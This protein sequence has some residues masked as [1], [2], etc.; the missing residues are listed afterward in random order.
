MVWR[1]GC[2]S[3]PWMSE[4]RRGSLRGALT[5]GRVRIR[6]PGPNAVHIFKVP[7]A[8]GASRVRRPRG[9]GT[10]RRRGHIVRQNFSQMIGIFEVRGARHFVGGRALH[11]RMCH[12]RILGEAGRQ[13]TR[14]KGPLHAVSLM[15]NRLPLQVE[16]QVQRVLRRR[17]LRTS[18]P[19]RRRTQS[20]RR[21]RRPRRRSQ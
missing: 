15:G 18:R 3:G 4:G 10:A 11:Y 8:T 9:R 5:A 12:Q 20:S 2:P 17:R 6:M 19:G 21:R 13:P 7:P 16:V 14:S 1:R